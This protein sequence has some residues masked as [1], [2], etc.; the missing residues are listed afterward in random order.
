MKEQKGFFAWFMSILLKTLKSSKFKTIYFLVLCAAI[1]YYLINQRENL[2]HLICGAKINLL[3][4]SFLFYWL[5]FLSQ[6]GS[7]YLV[8]RAVSLRIPYLQV[9][10]IISLAT[11]GKYLPGKI[12]VIGNYYLFSREVGISRQDIAQ[13]FV[14]SMGLWLLVGFF[15]GLPLIF[16]LSNYLKYL[17][18]LVPIMVVIFL[19]PKVLNWVLLTSLRLIQY[20]L[21]E[22]MP[23]S[24]LRLKEISYS[25]YL[26][27]FVLNFIN[28]VAGGM[29]LYL[30]LSSFTSVSLANFHFYVGALALSIIGEIIAIFAPGGIGVR[31]GIGIFLLSQITNVENALLAMISFRLIGTIL[32]LINGL[33]AI[34]CLK[35]KA[36]TKNDSLEGNREGGR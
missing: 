7:N 28:Y 5:V 12:A 22:Q 30:I 14:I 21:S 31:E 11:L 34:F 20:L 6:I 1:I 2:S 33:I 18:W 25:S 4:C 35:P 10:R 13:S 3:A 8:Y 16:T 17:V 23:T 19:Q 26:K 15:C 29:I 9:F 36:T 32:E 24:P 27:I